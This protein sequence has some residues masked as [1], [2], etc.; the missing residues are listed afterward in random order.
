MKSIEHLQKI[1]VLN[2]EVGPNINYLTSTTITTA[3]AVTL[4]SA[5]ILGGQI[6]RDPNGAGRTD[7]LP[8]AALLVA[9]LKNLAG[10]VG[11]QL[12]APISF[13]FVVQNDADAAETITI[14]AGSGATSQGTMTIAQSNSKRFNI[15]ITVLTPGSEAYVVRNRGT[16]T[17]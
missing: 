1:A 7:T 12:T 10:Q 16:Y 6:N 3:G 15:Q 14:A 13:D 8:T 2:A 5:Q 11:A 9:Y 17:T 4:T